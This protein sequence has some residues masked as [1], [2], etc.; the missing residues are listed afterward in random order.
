[1][2]NVDLSAQS[3]IISGRLAVVATCQTAGGT[4]TIAAS[5]GSALDLSRMAIR[6]D[7]VSTVTNATVLC[8]IEAGSIYSDISLGDYS[9]VVGTAG[10]VYVGGDSFESARFLNATAQ[11]VV[12]TYSFA[13][14]TAVTDITTLTEVIMLPS[15]HTA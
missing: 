5:A 6:I 11:S 3:I 13:A 12:L 7:N 2:A 1:M 4:I 8:T 14:A 15:G 9:F 10:S